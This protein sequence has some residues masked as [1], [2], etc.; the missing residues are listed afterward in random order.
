MANLKLKVVSQEK[1]L[2]DTE[3]SQITAPTSEGEITVLP[4]HIPLYTKM[5]DGVA[6]YLTDGQEHF[7]RL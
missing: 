5:Q 6:R 7:C 4:G 3:V 1:Q 2:I